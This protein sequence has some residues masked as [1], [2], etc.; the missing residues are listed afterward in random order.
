VHAIL[1]RKLETAPLPEQETQ[2]PLL[3]H[4]NIRGPDYF[5]QKEDE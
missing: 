4:D 3:V 2:L 1:V 5:D